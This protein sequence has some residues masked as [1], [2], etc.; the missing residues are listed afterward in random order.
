MHPS[1]F[2][3]VD[4]PYCGELCEIAVDASAGRQEYVEDCQV[5]CKPIQL[6]IR[7]GADGAPSIAARREDE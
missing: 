5:C 6:S 1:E 3:R 7:I 4:C 2:S